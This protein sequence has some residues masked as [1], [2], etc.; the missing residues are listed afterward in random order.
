MQNSCWSS[1]SFVNL[2]LSL[3]SGSLFL[4]RLVEIFWLDV[5]AWRGAVE[6]PFWSL[7]CN[8]REKKR[9]AVIDFKGSL[10]RWI[11]RSQ[12]RRVRGCLYKAR[13]MEMKWTSS[14]LGTWS[15]KILFEKWTCVSRCRI[16]Q[17]FNEVHPH[18]RHETIEPT[19][20]WTNLCFPKILQHLFSKRPKMNFKLLEAKRKAYCSPE[21]QSQ[22]GRERVWTKLS[23]SLSDASKRAIK[24]KSICLDSKIK[25]IT[26]NVGLEPT[27][28]R[29]PA[30]QALKVWKCARRDSLNKSRTLCQ[31][32]Q[33]G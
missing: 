24:S 9:R 26:P 17:F 13:A 30:L 10:S 29:W 23:S 18:L 25:V 3:L 33:P 7:K 19:R 31:L 28:L 16:I 15:I 21:W 12:K 32:S 22:S 14:K 11:W 5:Q 6:G 20:I 1:F 8:W 27:A 2:C 4:G